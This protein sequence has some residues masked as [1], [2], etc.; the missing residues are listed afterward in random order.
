MTIKE[1]AELCGR[2]QSTIRNWITS[3]NSADLSA[4]IAEAQQAKKPA[5]FTIEETIAIVRAGKNETLAN[6]LAEN[7][8]NRENYEKYLSLM[9]GLRGEIAKI[10]AKPTALPDPKETANRELEEFI[11]KTIEVDPKRIYRV[12]VHQL[13]HAYKKEASNPMGEH[14]FMHKIALD[15]PEFELVYSKKAWYFTRCELM[16]II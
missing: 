10:S 15:H 2:A 8:Q 4:K 5:N 13:Y 12:Y 14:Q 1:I 9:E 11:Q 6:L 7:A 3:A 16:R